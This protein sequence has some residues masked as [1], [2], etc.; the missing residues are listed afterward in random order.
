MI[1]C[2]AIQVGAL[3]RD[4]FDQVF[5]TEA[6]VLHSIIRSEHRHD[7]Y[8]TIEVGD[9]IYFDAPLVVAP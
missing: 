4:Q 2:T 6:T 8:P 7:T 3:E 1:L 9:V 5:I